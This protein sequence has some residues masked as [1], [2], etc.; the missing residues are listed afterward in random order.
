VV[1]GHRRKVGQRWPGCRIAG[2]HPGGSPPDPVPAVGRL[3]LVTYFLLGQPNGWRLAKV[4]GREQA[5]RSDPLSELTPQERRIL[6]LIGE[7]LTNR[8][9]GDRMYLAEKTVK[10][11]VS[12]LFAKLGMERRPR[13]LLMPPASL[14]GR[15]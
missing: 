8:Q 14:L 3:R 15:A 12:A 1:H 2:C 4:R 6:E 9:I 13:P 10:N 11:Y 7:G 5:Q